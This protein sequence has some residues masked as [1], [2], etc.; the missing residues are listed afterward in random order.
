MT[1]GRPAGPSPW[2]NICAAM[3]A[4]S[5]P[6]V[7]AAFLTTKEHHLAE[8]LQFSH[9]A[10]EFLAPRNGQPA[11]MVVTTSGGD[12]ASALASIAAPLA[13]VQMLVISPHA[14]NRPALIADA[15]RRWPLA[16]AAY[17]DEKVSPSAYIFADLRPCA[18]TDPGHVHTP[19]CRAFTTING[20]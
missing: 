14:P 18:N 6:P 7:V 13:S 11:D 1:S 20:V 15:Q 2:E 10:C 4:G 19:V 5:R 12:I 16:L 17:S 3:P 8:R 9:Y